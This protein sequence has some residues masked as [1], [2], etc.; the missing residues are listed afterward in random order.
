METSSSQSSTVYKGQF[1][2][3]GHQMKMKSARVLLSSTDINI[4][5]TS[6][7]MLCTALAI[8]KATAFRI[9]EV[10][11]SQVASLQG[12]AESRGEFERK[13]NMQSAGCVVRKA[14]LH[15]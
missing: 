10:R 4:Q 11:P 2:L 7:I 5:H 9:M 8:L 6:L 12:W 15:N 13:V 1:G 3:T 14:R